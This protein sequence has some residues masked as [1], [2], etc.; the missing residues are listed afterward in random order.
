MLCQHMLYKMYSG[1]LFYRSCFIAVQPGLASAVQ[2]INSFIRRNKRSGH[3]ADNVADVSE[4]FV[5]ADKALLKRVLA[6][7][8]HTLY[9]LLPPRTSYNYNLRK[10]PHN[11]ELFNC[12]SRKLD[13][14]NQ[15]LLFVAYI[16]VLTNYTSTFGLEQYLATHLLFI[17]FCKL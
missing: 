2:Q 4:Q 16:L 9:N 11:R 6:N 5:V 12:P 17:T 13:F 14:T 10:R 3:C 8:R 15:I 7:P 1:P